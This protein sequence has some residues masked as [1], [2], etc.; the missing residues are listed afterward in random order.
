MMILVDHNLKGYIVLLRGTLA[1]DGWLD[2][3]SIIVLYLEN[4]LGVSRLFI[5]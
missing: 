1:V 2:W 5:P 3:L 4:Y